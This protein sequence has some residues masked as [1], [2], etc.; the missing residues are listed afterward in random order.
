MSLTT[1]ENNIKAIKLHI[2]V[3]GLY[4]LGFLFTGVL[5]INNKETHNKANNLCS[6]SYN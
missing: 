3:R 5:E 6:F 1:L 4:N 2:C